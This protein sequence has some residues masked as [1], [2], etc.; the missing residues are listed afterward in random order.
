MM[1]ERDS[2]RL[3]AIAAAN[4]TDKVLARAAEE[5]AEAAA[6]ILQYRRVLYG[7]SRYAFESLPARFTN[8]ASE[9]AD[10]GIMVDQLKLIF[11]SL[12]KK[13]D[14]ERE[15]KIARTIERYGINEHIVQEAADGTDA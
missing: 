5:F 13:I 6:A 2:M 3:A 15:R 9:L 14:E 4:P 11:K 10:A 12:A 1:N 7:D 8:M